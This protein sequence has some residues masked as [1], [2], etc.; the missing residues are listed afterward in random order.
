MCSE[1]TL[2]LKTK[3]FLFLVKTFK[4]GRSIWIIFFYDQEELWKQ[5]HTKLQFHL[6]SKKA[7]KR[8]IEFTNTF[9]FRNFPSSTNFL[10][11]AWMV[12]FTTD[13]GEPSVLTVLRLEPF[14]CTFLHKGGGATP[15]NYKV[16]KNS[17]CYPYLD[18]KKMKQTK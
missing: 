5:W 10:R 14:G 9:T 15:D 16:Q 18:R 11:G 2:W 3:W 4:A 13:L 6:N 12:E 8:N 17:G 1:C 7:L